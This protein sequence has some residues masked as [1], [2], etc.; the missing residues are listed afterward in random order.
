MQAGLPVS[1][2]GYLH[3]VAQ[4]GEARMPELM[5]Q[6][7]HADVSGAAHWLGALLPAAEQ[8]RV[9]LTFKLPCHPDWQAVLHEV[10]ARGVPTLVTG[11]SN[12]MQLLWA[13]AQGASFVAPYVGRL[14]ADGRDVWSLIEACVAIQAHGPQLLAAS[15][16]SADV[17][18]RLMAA[19]A[20]AVTLRPE[21]AIQLATDPMTLAAMAQFDRDVLTS[22][23]HN[24]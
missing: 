7:P 20:H 1:L 3:L 4:A 23:A 2:P 14:Q 13:Q 17:L 16:K 18:S 22:Q 11:L 12:P 8:A 9:R 21:L 24:I 10:Q 15:I 19:G 6:L 5:L